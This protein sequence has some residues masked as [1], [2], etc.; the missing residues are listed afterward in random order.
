M[1]SAR[2]AVMGNP[3]EHSQSPL[4]HRLFAEQTQQDLV[5][6]A[7]LVAHEQF[8][9]AVATFWQQGGQGLNVTVPF[10]QQAWALAEVKHEGAELA[11]AVN[12]LLQQEGRVHGYNTDGVGLVRDLRDNLNIT[13][14]DKSILMLGAGGA[15]RGVLLPLL[16]CQPKQIWIAN[17]SAQK[18]EQL[19]QK[20]APFGPVVGSGFAAIKGQF[21][22]VI[23]ATAA[24]LTRQVP[25]IDPAL[26][27]PHSVCYDLMYG[28]VP[29][30]FVEWAR[31]QGADVAVD[32]L[33]MLVEQAAE[34]FRIWRDVS[35]NTA[36]VMA[37][38]RP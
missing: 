24:G 31:A 18:A 36:A 8:P 21:E 23:H 30:A 14:S 16:Q 5:Y 9:A 2:Y 3:I 1:T 19:A 17:R 7:L 15:A 11:G 20:F 26:I 12:T 10:K 6:H 22:V 13:L 25:D 38:L 32:G 35:P 27:Q 4:I 34:A 37:Q 28:Q 29:T 33:G